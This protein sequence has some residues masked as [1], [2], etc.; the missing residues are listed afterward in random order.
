MS[1]EVANNVEAKMGRTGKMSEMDKKVVR[2]TL[3]NDMWEILKQMASEGHRPP[4][5]QLEVVVMDAL[6]G[7]KSSQQWAAA[8]GADQVVEGNH[9]RTEVAGAG[10]EEMPF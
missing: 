5:M 7:W 10:E 2:I 3:P 9:E 8:M 1:S 6:R 4:L